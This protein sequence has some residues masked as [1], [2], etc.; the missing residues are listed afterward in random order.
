MTFLIA[1]RY[2]AKEEK[3]KFIRNLCVSAYPDIQPWQVRSACMDV[4]KDSDGE[5]RQPCSPES[6]RELYYDYLS[7]LLDPIEGHDVARHDSDLVKVSGIMSV[8]KNNFYLKAFFVSKLRRTPGMVHV[9]SG[10]RL[11]WRGG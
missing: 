11:Q 5:S 4:P 8:S 9:L 2:E 3:R 7:L 10:I 1:I 6:M